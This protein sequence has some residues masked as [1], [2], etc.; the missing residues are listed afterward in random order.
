MQKIGFSALALSIAFLPG[1]LLA[2]DAETTISHGFSTFGA[3]KYLP[4]FPYFDYVDPEA[5]K[6]GTIS[7]QGTGASRTFDSLNMFILAGEPAQGLPR[8]YDTLMAR[9]FDEPDAVY[10]LLAESIEYPEDRSYVIYRLRDGAAFHDGAPVTAEDVRFT[11]GILEEEGLP[12]YRLLLEDVAEVTVID[13]LTVRVDFAEDATTRDLPAEIGLLP[14]LPAHYY[15][16]VDFTRST[17]EPPVGSGP[18]L[19]EDADP[20][21]SVT[22]C[23]DPDYWGA[24]LPVNIGKDNFDCVVYEYF[25]DRTAAFEALK[26]GAYLF[27]EEFSSAI[28]ATGYAFPALENGWVVQEVIGDNRPSGTQGF[29]L[30]M[31]K[32]KFRDI[33][34]REA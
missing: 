31:R 24:E 3:L 7:F 14:I 10:G 12:T 25:A 17:I 16:D 19:V 13:E 34:V 30:N 15:A 11:I 26:S 28:W 21:R 20:G 23:R 29:W 22:Y 27:H 1:T 8:L 6:G 9:A 33:R 32:E 2:T 5:P 4:D 18:Y